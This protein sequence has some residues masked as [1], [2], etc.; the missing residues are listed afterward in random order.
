MKT[1]VNH[2]LCDDATFYYDHLPVRGEKVDRTKITT[3]RGQRVPEGATG[4]RC[5]SC[6]RRLHSA[7]E[8]APG[9]NEYDM[10][11]D[12][13]MSVIYKVREAV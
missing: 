12:E 13:D 11:S 3:L 5:G 4:M 1:L 10:S 8:L 2:V 6:G 7:N 9:L